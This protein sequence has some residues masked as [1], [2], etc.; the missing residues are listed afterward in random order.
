MNSIFG[1]LWLFISAIFMWKRC[2]YIEEHPK[3]HRGKRAAV[4]SAEDRE[5]EVSTYGHWSAHFRYPESVA[6]RVRHGLGRNLGGER[7]IPCRLF[8]DFINCE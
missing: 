5:G 6:A 4:E 3:Y 1:V 2:L 8:E 7:Y